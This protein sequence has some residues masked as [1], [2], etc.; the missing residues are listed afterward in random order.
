MVGNSGSDYNPVGC[1]V[2]ESIIVGIADSGRTTDGGGS[3]NGCTG[4]FC[5]QGLND[6]SDL[7]N[8]YLNVLN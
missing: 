6:G 7:S 1:V 3:G 8:K 2:L 4:S 5:N